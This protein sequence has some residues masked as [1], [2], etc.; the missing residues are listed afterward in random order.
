MLGDDE[1]DDDEIGNLNAIDTE[2]HFGGGGGK[3]HDHNI[4]GSSRM[5]LTTAY[6]QK[7]MDL[8][9]LILRRKIQKA[10]KLKQ[11]EEQVDK[12]ESMDEGFSDLAAMLSFRDKEKD[13]REHLEKKRAGT[14]SQEDMEFE[15][16]D[17]EMR[18]FQ[19]IE[20]KVKATDR[21]KTPEEIA[22]EEAQ[23]LHELETRRLARMH[24]DFDD[25]DF[26]DVESSDDDNNNRTLP[27]KKRK[28]H[29][30]PEALDNDSD[31]EDTNVQ[32]KVR[33][34]ADGLVR[35]DKHGN[36]IGKV[37][38]SDS[39]QQEMFT[40][41]S[42]KSVYEV[43]T[44]VMASYR[45]NEQYD[46]NESWFAGVVSEIHKDA[47]NNVI[48]YDIEYDDGDFEENVEPRH[49]K[50]LEQSFEENAKQA[51]RNDEDIALKRKRQK[52]KEK[53]R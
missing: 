17:Q 13:I 20:R 53:A 51:A 12:F 30:T 10:E 24:G 42:D 19:F 14:L 21:T 5:D 7:K 22:K 46:G 4:Y 6:S 37:G 49:V 47:R 32:P 26:S 28:T 45:A 8:D 38:D 18:Q 1:D 33:F 27:K 52:A 15:E 48:R 39:Q 29:L 2:M 43:G 35:I 50:I 44:K 11:K 41:I 36:V 31:N 16:W 40:R 9:E 23:R 25:D 34:T 3:N